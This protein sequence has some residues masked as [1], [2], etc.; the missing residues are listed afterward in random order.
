[1]ILQ[2]EGA[3]SAGRFSIS[4]STNGVVDYSIIGALRGLFGYEA[5]SIISDN[6]YDE[7]E[8]NRLPSITSDQVSN[9]STTLEYPDSDT[10]VADHVY[11]NPVSD[12]SNTLNVLVTPNEQDSIFDYIFEKAENH[13]IASDKSKVSG[14]TEQYK[15]IFDNAGMKLSDPANIIE[16]EGHSG[17][18]NVKYKEYVLIS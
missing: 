13:H 8:L 7:R 18:H 2:P 14:Y 4:S 3:G 11:R 5:D 17:A 1:L 15:K 16:L 6:S 12:E 9:T 10:S